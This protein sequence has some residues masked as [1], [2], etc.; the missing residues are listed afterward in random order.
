M[1][2]VSHFV[3]F[4]NGR[5][6]LSEGVSDKNIKVNESVRIIQFRASAE[7]CLHRNSNLPLPRVILMRVGVSSRGLIL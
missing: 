7:I 2:F 3:S 5:A 1:V 6:G 4:N